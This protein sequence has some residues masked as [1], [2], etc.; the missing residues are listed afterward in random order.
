MYVD[1]CQ[2]IGKEHDDVLE[3]NS[4]YMLIKV[5]DYSYNYSLRK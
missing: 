3:Y 2:T 1:I 5:L 4:H